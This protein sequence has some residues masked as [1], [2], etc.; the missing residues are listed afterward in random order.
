MNEIERKVYT[1]SEVAMMLGISR[2]T[3]YELINKKQIP[4]LLLGRRRVI[5]KQAFDDWI[6]KSLR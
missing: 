5:P 4:V 6:S 2:S 3:T 1:V